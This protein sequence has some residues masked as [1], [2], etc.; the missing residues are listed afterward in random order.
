MNAGTIKWQVPLGLSSYGGF[1]KGVPSLGGGS[2]LVFIAA[3]MD[4]RYSGLRCRERRRALARRSAGRRPSDANDICDRRSAV[5]WSS[6]L[7]GTTA[8]APPEAMRSLPLPC[9]KSSRLL[10]TLR[11]LQELLPC[12]LRHH[13]AVLPYRSRQCAL[14]K[15]F[16]MLGYLD[17]VAVA[18]DRGCGVSCL[19]GNSIA[20]DLRT[21]DGPQTLR[22]PN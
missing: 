13:N 12:W 3:A 2:G 6:P 9:Q 4:S 21:H 16:T 1:I 8:W 18:A 17:G 22:T 15:R 11:V 5:F 7:A 19:T 20:A 14:R 10:V